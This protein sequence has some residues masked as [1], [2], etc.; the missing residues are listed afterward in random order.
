MFQQNS[1]S[2]PSRQRCCW[3]WCVKDFHK[4]TK[5]TR[6]LLV[7]EYPSARNVCAVSRSWGFLS[8][9]RVQG[10]LRAGW[11]GWWL[12]CWAAGGW[13]LGAECCVPV[14]SCAA[15]VPGLRACLCF[16]GC[17]CCRLVFPS[18]LLRVLLLLPLPLALVSFVA[19]WGS[20]LAVFLGVFADFEFFRISSFVQ[21]G[22]ESAFAP[23]LMD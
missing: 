5:Q 12:A 4:R 2:E 16:L 21:V 10:G 7:V 23:Q 9:S 14:V 20:C 15:V 18:L 22:C 13:V 11:A 3:W 8:C 1:T 19:F 17:S 6:E